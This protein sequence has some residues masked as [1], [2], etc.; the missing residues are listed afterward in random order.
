MRWNHSTDARTTGHVVS[1]AYSIRK[2]IRWDRQGRLCDVGQRHRPDQRDVYTFV[3]QSHATK[4]P[5]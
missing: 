4:I 5:C 3:V 1:Y 2:S